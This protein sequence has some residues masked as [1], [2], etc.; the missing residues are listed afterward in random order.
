[1]AQAQEGNILS[2][3]TLSLFYATDFADQLENSILPSLKAGQPRQK[4]REPEPV[5]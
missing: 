5:P 4:T 2:R 1:L 3:T